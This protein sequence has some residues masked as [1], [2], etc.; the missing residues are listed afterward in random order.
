MPLYKQQQG[1]SDKPTL[2][3]L[4]GFL[5]SLRD[6]NETIDLLKDNFHCI[7]IDLPGHGGSVATEGSIKDGFN[8][9]HQL[10]KNILDDLNIVQYSLIGYSL[11][12]RIALD[13][14]RSQNDARLTTLLLESSHIGL[15]DEDSKERRFMHDH[16]WA[17]KFATEGII[18]TLYEWYD[19][20]IFSDLSDRKK[21][22]IIDKRADN[23]GVPLANMLLATSLGKQING[24]PY[25]QETNI[26]VHY[27]FGGK[28]KKFKKTA[29]QLNNLKHVNI[30]E[31]EHAGHNIHQ[32]NALE[33]AQ[34]IMQH[35]K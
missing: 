5:G 34:Y 10:I 9:C 22:M 27:C 21:E 24:L 12:G 14:A 28:D 4:H 15:S 35:L 8:H 30:V 20:A 2:V 33:Y 17:K 23:Y 29:T 16:S 3:F 26:P 11:G 25:L 1:C 19:Q 18:E 31:F 7:S 13:Y 32:Y 6:W